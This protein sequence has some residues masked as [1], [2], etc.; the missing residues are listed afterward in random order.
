MFPPNAP[1]PESDS[2]TTLTEESPSFSSLFLFDF[3]RP[4][5]LS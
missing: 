4:P 1:L 5:R 2:F 3:E